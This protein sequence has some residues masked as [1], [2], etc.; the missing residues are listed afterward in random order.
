MPKFLL[1]ANLSWQTAKFIESL[2][3]E[4]KTV[5]YFKFG[6]AEDKEIIKLARQKKMILI[7]LDSDFGE[8]YYFSSPKAVGIIILKLKNQ[9]VESVNNILENFIKSRLIEKKENQKALIV[10]SEKKIRIRRK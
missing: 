5:A 10:I 2:G 6:N 8:L 7:T 3:Y 4:T 9:T 1:D